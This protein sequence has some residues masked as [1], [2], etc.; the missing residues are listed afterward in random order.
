MTHYPS[1]LIIQPQAEHKYTVIW[2]HGLGAN[3]NDFFNLA[4]RLKFKNKPHT[5]FIFP[6]A[7]EQKVSINGF[8]IMPSWYDIYNLDNTK[9]INLE[10]LKNSSL[11]VKGFI[12]KEVSSATNEDHI[13]LAGFSQGGVVAL[14]TALSGVLAH[15]VKSVLALST[16]HPDVDLLKPSTAKTPSICFMHGTQDTI[17]PIKLAKETCVKI[18][19]LNY[20]PQFTSYPMAHEVCLEQIK[21]INTFF[22]MQCN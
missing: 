6:N 8:A 17:I 16:Y 4:P 5:K 2:L 13:I 18:E 3:A 9:N 15:S 20:K 10:D 22:S 1:P 7:S 21:D 11:Y 19:Q 14:H 12:D